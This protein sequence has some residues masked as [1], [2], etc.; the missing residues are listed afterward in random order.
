MYA[1]MMKQSPPYGYLQGIFNT[2][3]TKPRSLEHSVLRMGHPIPV[4]KDLGGSQ[5]ENNIRKHHHQSRAHDTHTRLVKAE[6][7]YARSAGRIPR[8]GSPDKL[9]KYDPAIRVL[10]SAV[11][12]HLRS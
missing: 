8:H 11:G 10:R 5:R 4:E 9:G 7:L 12:N 2:C 6:G 3:S 1:Q